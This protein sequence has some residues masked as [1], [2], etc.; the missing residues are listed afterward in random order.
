MRL[1]R[2][3]VPALLAFVAFSAD[4]SAGQYPAYGDT[5]W[6]Y[7]GKRDCCNEAIAIA[8]EQS[9]L[10][11]RGVGGTPS[12]MRGGVQ[13]RGF[14]SWESAQDDDGAVAFRCRA[15]ATVPCR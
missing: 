7:A 3:V 2:I 15:E 1:H 8:Q 4:A 14:C 11:C 12:P 10:A 5:G 13:R 6:V 9:A